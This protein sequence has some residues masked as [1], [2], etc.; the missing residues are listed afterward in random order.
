VQAYMP[1]VA[2]EAPRAARSLVGA[3]LIVAALLGPPLAGCSH[4]PTQPAAGDA[5]GAGG[6]GSTVSMAGDR[7]FAGASAFLLA[8]DGCRL[9]II[10]GQQLVTL[11]AATAGDLPGA[12][13]VSL[14]H[15]DGLGDPSSSLRALG[16]C[17]GPDDPG[18][19]VALAAAAEYADEGRHYFIP[20][21]GGSTVR[22]L[23]DQPLRCSWAFSS[24][25]AL[26]VAVV[27][28]DRGASDFSYCAR[29]LEGLGP[30]AWRTAWR[31]P[32]DS[33]L[34]SVQLASPGVAVAETYRE[35]PVTGG[36]LT[37]SQLWRID[38]GPLG[39]G[40]AGASPM[41]LRS[42]LD[43]IDRWHLSPDGSSLAALGFRGSDPRAC[44]VYLSGADPVE[45]GPC[46]VAW[47]RWSADGRRLCYRAPDQRLLSYDIALTRIEAVPLGTFAGGGECRATPLQGGRWLLWDG[48]R[49]A[50][51][52]GQGRDTSFIAGGHDP[53]TLKV[54]KD[55]LTV[56]FYDG[57]A[58]GVRLLRLLR[59]DPVK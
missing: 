16:W 19:L 48:S 5:D 41:R 4:A 56:V 31:A 44:L 1:R 11:A 59:L 20:L 39:A 13:A 46:D 9:V 32:G 30:A 24:G 49:M 52:D 36:S 28:H 34:R 33:S 22:Q 42:G 2:P 25:A 50:V 7:F 40:S 18:L 3:L 10:Q 35:Q 21:A 51:V 23:N 12:S 8:P 14:T 57:E 47:A 54:S 53:E 15:A 6:G 27:R 17:D 37:Q 58:G 38:I 29:P 26:D 55:L 43:S 45:L